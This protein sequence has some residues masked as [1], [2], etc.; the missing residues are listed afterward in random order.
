MTRSIAIFAG[1]LL[2]AAA[3]GAPARAGEIYEYKVEHPLYGDIGTYTNTIERTA[4]GV[5]IASKLR[6]SV[7][8]LG[9]VL[10][11]EEADRVEQWQGDRLV[12]FNGVTDRNGTKLQVHGEAQGQ[13]FVINAPAG[14]IYAPA[15]VHPSNPWSPKS[16]ASDTVMSTV[17]GKVFPA[18]VMDNGE[19]T[20]TSAGV[21]IKARKFEVDSNKRQFVWLDSRGV[22]VRFRTEESGAE[23][24]LVLVRKQ[25]APDQDIAAAPSVQ[26]NNTEARP[27]SNMMASYVGEE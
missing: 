17:T 4:A 18:R 10:Y 24:D 6:I 23:I 26:G 1:A 9:A 27:A 20:V 22:P 15:D 5:L 8:L 14:T 3:F 11:R 16:L 2:T 7:K 21:P 19:E 25:A 12:L 13:S